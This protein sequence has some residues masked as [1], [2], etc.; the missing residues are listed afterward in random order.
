M[1]M[2]PGSYLSG[3]EAGTREERARLQRALDGGGEG[4][5]ALLLVIPLVLLLAWWAYPV[6]SL[7][8]L[9]AWHVLTFL[10]SQL[11]AVT[12][13]SVHWCA[14]SSPLSLLPNVLSAGPPCS[15]KPGPHE[16]FGYDPWAALLAAIVVFLATIVFFV[17]IERRL[18]HSG[19]YVGARHAWRCAF[20]GAFFLFY[21]HTSDNDRA[22]TLFAQIAIPIAFGIAAHFL[23]TYLPQ[24]TAS[25]RSRPAPASYRIGAAA[26]LPLIFLYAFAFLNTGSLDLEPYIQQYASANAGDATGH[27]VY[28][29]D[30]LALAH[31][32]HIATEYPLELDFS[33]GRTCLLPEGTRVAW[34]FLHST[35]ALATGDISFP[36]DFCPQLKVRRLTVA[37]GQLVERSS[38]QEKK[39]EGTFHVGNIVRG[40][41][42]YESQGTVMEQGVLTDTAIAQRAVCEVPALSQALLLKYQP[43]RQRATRVVLQDGVCQDLQDRTVLVL[44]QDFR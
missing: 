42:L 38:K 9:L 7:L 10:L 18:T 28:S 17:P 23:F 39:Q 37:A 25:A 31:A 44:P 34:K 40:I 35:P 24:I 14:N 8:S 21:L 6:T 30:A 4:G 13:A 19:L 36:Q 29:D 1:Q 43:I 27:R 32:D 5:L 2:D 33:D 11:A 26:A 20:P 16:L 12:F 3:K 41:T 22:L 15:S